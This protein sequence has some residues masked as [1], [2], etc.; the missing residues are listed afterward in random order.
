[1]TKL[2]IIVTAIIIENCQTSINALS[3]LI[4]KIV[5]YSDYLGISFIL[6]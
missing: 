3:I 4:I 1:M 2:S 5:Y 6:Y